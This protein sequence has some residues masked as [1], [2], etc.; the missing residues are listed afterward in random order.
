MQP[1]VTSGSLVDAA[2]RSQ[3]APKKVMRLEC[4]G[5]GRPWEGVHRLEMQLDGTAVVVLLR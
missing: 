5:C 1:T 4:S 3:V 2:T